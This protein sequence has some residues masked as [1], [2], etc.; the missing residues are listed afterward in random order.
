[1]AASTDV[2]FWAYTWYLMNNPYKSHLSRDDIHWMAEKFAA[3]NST[4]I[5]SATDPG[6]TYTDIEWPDQA[7]AGSVTAVGNSSTTTENSATKVNWTLVDA[8]SQVTLDQ[9]WYPEQMT[10]TGA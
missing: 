4:E 7:G 10:S 2:T 8:A 3:T 5:T 9:A 1:M 6:G